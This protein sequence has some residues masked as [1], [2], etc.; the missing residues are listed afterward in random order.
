MTFAVEQKASAYLFNT[1]KPA[2]VTLAPGASS[3]FMLEWSAGPTSCPGTAFVLLTPPGD[4]ATLQ[5]ASAMEICAGPVIVSPI[6][7]NS[8]FR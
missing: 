5:I 1:Q 7:E 3:Y 6:F 8:P 4:Q 2:L